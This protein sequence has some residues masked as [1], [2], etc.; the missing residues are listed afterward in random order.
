MV[1]QEGEYLCA[2]CRSAASL[3]RAP[4]DGGEPLGVMEAMGHGWQLVTRDLWP[5]CLLGIVF[6]L[7][8]G[9]ANL[10]G[11]VLGLIPFIGYIFQ[12]AILICVNPPLQAGLV[13]AVLRKIDGAPADTANL[14]EGFR[15]RF[16]QSIVVMLP[17]WGVT[18]VMVGALAI[19]LVI[20]M[21]ALGPTVG[22][23]RGAALG[24]VVILVLVLAALVI[25]FVSMIMNTVMFLAFVALWDTHDSGW[26]AFVAGAR[27]VMANFGPACGVTGL[28][29]LL[30]LAAVVVG[31]LALCI[32]LIFTGAFVMVWM[33]ATYAYLYRSWQGS[34]DGVGF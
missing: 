12:L 1:D 26:A 6:T 30:G 34:R 13:Y 17:V 10:V 28:F 7:V 14:F 18:V 2:N 3:R 20:L 23:G 33:T 4:V 5:V 21:Y 11:G 29:L 22:R 9:G 25:M 31:V 16:G 19:G 8:Q 24:P 27:L 32:G 15:S